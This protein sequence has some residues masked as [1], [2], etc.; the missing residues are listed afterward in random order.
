MSPSSGTASTYVEV[1]GHGGVSWRKAA[2]WRNQP[3]YGCAISALAR[4]GRDAWLRRPDRWITIGYV[5]DLA[6]LA[7][8]APVGLWTL[9]W[10]SRH[11][12]LEAVESE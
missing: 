7:N 6:T 5:T 3:M 10:R 12:P 4:H 8:A 2:K 1:Q 11:S 9:R